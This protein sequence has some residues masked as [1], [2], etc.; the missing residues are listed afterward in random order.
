[1][2]QELTLP[3]YYKELNIPY[4]ASKHDIRNILEELDKKAL[5]TRDKIY[6]QTA[7]VYLLKEKEKYDNYLRN[8]GVNIP[9]SKKNRRYK[10]QKKVIAI[11][12]VVAIG[13][14]GMAGSVIQKTISKDEASNVCVE[15]EVQPGDSMNMLKDEYGLKDV[16]FS[17]YEVSGFQRQELSN[18]TSGFIAAGDV[19]IGR[20]TKEQADKLVEEG[21]ARIISIDEAV[22]LLE[23]NGSLSGKFRGY[24]T[25]DSNYT[26]Y[27]PTNE[28][29]L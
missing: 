11:G 20:T 8:R 13:L 7:G 6:L 5:N 22:E 9:H 26:F 23:A 24:V 18:G 28:K 27:V 15:Y 2:A 3:N 14:S 21:N 1:M 12:M 10:L 25:G 17:Y 4:N 19:I 29:S 16:G